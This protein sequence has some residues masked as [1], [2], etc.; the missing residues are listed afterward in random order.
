MLE[1]LKGRREG[2]RNRNINL[3]TVNSPCPL[4][5]THYQSADIPPPPPATTD[6]A[7]PKNPT[8]FEFL[9]DLHLKKHQSQKL[10]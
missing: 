4:Q 5:S 2:R 1:L 8:L 3:K 10:N 9:W 7:L 6:L